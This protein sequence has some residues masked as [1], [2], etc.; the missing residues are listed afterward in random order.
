V[1]RLALARWLELLD[2]VL[3][4][5]FVFSAD[6]QGQWLAARHATDKERGSYVLGPRGHPAVDPAATFRKHGE[7]SVLG[8]NISL[9]ATSNFVFE[10]AAATG[11]TPDSSGVAPLIAAQLAARGV[12]PPRLRYD[13]AA[14]TP[15]V[16]HQVHQASQGQTQLLARLQHAGRRS[17]RFGPTDFTLLAHQQLRCPN[18]Q[19][20]STAYRA[21]GG[22]GW[23]YRFRAQQCAGCPLW[24]KCRGDQ[25]KP[26]RHRQVFVSD[27][28]LHQQQ[29]LA[30]TLTAA[31][32]QEMK[33]RAH[34]ERII[35]ALVRYNGA[36]RAKAY[37]LQN[38]DY[39]V[40]MAAMAFNLKRWAKRQQQE[41]RAARRPTQPPPDS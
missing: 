3:H 27:Y 22:D 7:Q 2:K 38:A 35:A 1:E 36:R 29:A 8:Y 14:G 16:F 34:I 32:A 26:T 12:V 28:I 4:D 13:Q 17:P 40:K 37:G 31:F 10:I 23:T 18:G 15:K 25:V 9:A 21:G 5:E 19:I 39:Q 20:S 41:E 33:Q 11:A 30:Y 6:E 24:D